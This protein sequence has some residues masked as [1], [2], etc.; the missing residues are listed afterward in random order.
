MFKVSN[1]AK[2]FDLTGGFII[3]KFRLLVINLLY[4]QNKYIVRQCFDVLLICSKLRDA[5]VDKRDIYESI[6]N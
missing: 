3:Q 6:R 5:P 1:R 4:A 2:G